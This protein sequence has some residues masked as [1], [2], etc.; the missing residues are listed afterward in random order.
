MKFYT[1][2]ETSFFI[3]PAV[4]LYVCT[5]DFFRINIRGESKSHE[6]AQGH[7]DDH[8]LVLSHQEMHVEC[9]NDMT[10]L[11][12]VEF[13]AKWKRKY[14]GEVGNALLQKQ[15]TILNYAHSFSFSLPRP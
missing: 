4:C 11:D 9:P 8:K 10:D 5:I 2:T 15:L 3:S 14:F 13:H 1:E 6:G 12:A 7:G